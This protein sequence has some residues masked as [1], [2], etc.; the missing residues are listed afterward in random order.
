M[1]FDTVTLEAPGDG[2]KHPVETVLPC[3]LAFSVISSLDTSPDIFTAFFCLLPPAGRLS[4][5]PPAFPVPCFQTD[6]VA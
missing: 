4:S 2:L 1:Q 3:S 6:V 5:S